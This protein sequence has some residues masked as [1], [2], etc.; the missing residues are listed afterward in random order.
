MNTD[1]PTA[2][3]FGTQP[4]GVDLSQMFIA[5]SWSA[6]FGGGWH[7]FGIAP[8]LAVQFFEAQ[9]VQAFGSFSADPA[10]LTNNG[11]DQSTGFGARVGYLGRWTER[12]SVGFAYQTEI[13]M[14]EFGDYAGLFAGAGDFDI[15]EN[16]VV[17]IAYRLTDTAVF[18]LDY[19]EI[20]YSGVPAVGNPLLPAIG[21]AFMGDPASLLGRPA[22]PGFG[23]QDMSVIKAG[24]QWGG[25]PW[26]WRVGFST[27]DQ[28]I[29]P[30]EVLFNILAP[31]VMEEHFTVGF[32]RKLG[33]GELNL[34]FMYAPSVS[35]QG[36]NPL[37]VPGF[38]TIALEMD[39][40]DLE[41]GYSW[42]F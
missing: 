6:R 25:G 20:I 38:Q 40:F 16:W 35:V 26:T 22:G 24:L 2:T 27:G 14:E 8:I 7:S 34:S 9:G 41:I 17:G 33:S 32:S 28:P 19:Q 31:G 12:F 15:P 5:P 23:W 18:V 39:Q 11:H 21:R 13:D 30:T 4:T 10:N 1:W 42:G 37:E 29:P 36:P 3:F